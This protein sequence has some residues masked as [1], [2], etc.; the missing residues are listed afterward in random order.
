[1]GVCLDGQKRPYTY[2]RKIIGYSR[3]I[4][5]EDN[6]KIDEQLENYICKIYTKKI[7]VAQDFYVK[8]LI[9]INLIYFLFLLQI[10]IF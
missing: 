7:S 2:E 10:I 3:P 6:L 9:L 4:T 8:Y 1:M 5:R